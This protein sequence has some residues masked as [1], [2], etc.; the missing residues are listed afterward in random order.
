MH[1]YKLHSVCIAWFKCCKY[2][3]HLIQW[4]FYIQ[5]ERDPLQVSGVGWLKFNM[6]LNVIGWFRINSDPTLLSGC[7]H[8]CKHITVEPACL[9]FGT[10][11]FTSS[12]IFF[13]NIYLNIFVWGGDGLAAKLFFM[14][15]ANL[16]LFVSTNVF[17]LLFFWCRYNGC[18]LYSDYLVFIGW[19]SVIFTFLLEKPFK[20]ELHFTSHNVKTIIPGLIFFKSQNIWKL[21]WRL[22][23]IA[24]QV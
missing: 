10:Y 22:I 2:G 7:E 1:S 11:G 4:F 5:L 20:N 24:K 18:Q 14:E 17:L 15:N 21:V 9:Q 3:L 19:P 6:R 13:F 16:S 23:S 12:L 8:F